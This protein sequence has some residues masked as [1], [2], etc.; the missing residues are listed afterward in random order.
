MEIIASHRSYP[1]ARAMHHLGK[2]FI[3]YVYLYARRAYCNHKPPSTIRRRVVWGLEHETRLRLHM[4]KGSS[5]RRCS[6]GPSCAS[7]R[8]TTEHS[9]CAPGDRTAIVRLISIDQLDCCGMTDYIR[10]SPFRVVEGAE[11]MPRLKAPDHCA[12]ASQV[13]GLD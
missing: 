6:S 9:Y 1:V 7:H 2:S 4:L 13:R 10:P 3:I 8:A 11:V 12:F 5:L